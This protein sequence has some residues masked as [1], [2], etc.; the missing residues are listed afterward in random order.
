MTSGADLGVHSSMLP[1][2]GGILSCP[3][4]AS[5]FLRAVLTERY[6]NKLQKEHQ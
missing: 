5:D 2:G 3:Q 6:K 4:S 1:S